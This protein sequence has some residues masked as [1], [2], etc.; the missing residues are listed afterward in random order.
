RLVDELNIDIG[1]HQDSGP[2]REAKTKR[3]EIEVLLGHGSAGDQVIGRAECFES[4]STDCSRSI[5]KSLVVSI[6]TSFSATKSGRCFAI[7]AAMAA[8][9]SSGLVARMF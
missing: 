2:V 8:A 3:S 7:S 4:F 9:R 5:L 6:H 1:P